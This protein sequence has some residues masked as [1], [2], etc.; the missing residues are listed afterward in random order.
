MAKQNYFDGLGE[1]EI[2]WLKSKWGFFSASQ[3][4]NLT[5]K[6]RRPMTPEELKARP[7]GSKLT[8][9][10][11]VFGDAALSYIHKV[12]TERLTEFDVNEENF[13]SRSMRRGK[14][15]E[16]I[17][18][19]N[20]NKRLGFE[21]KNVLEYYGGD[22]PIFTM[23]DEYSGVSPDVLAI[24]DRKKKELIGNVSFGVEL[25]NPDPKQHVYYLAHVRTP[26]ELQAEIPFHYGQV[27]KAMMT[28]KTDLWLWAS[29][30]ERMKNFADRL[31][32]VEV[33]A[34]KS[35]QLNLLMR[36]KMAEKELDDYIE[37]I[38]RRRTE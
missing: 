23:F 14:L 17:S 38:T 31:L 2:N 9:V 7:Q 21:G 36:L 25:K 16:P 11:T 26:K 3:I 13:E 29:F 8:T 12:A 10:E 37:R 28:Y 4:D 27:Q 24:R 22:N 1:K 20:L 15:N 32:I 5:K 6:G 34:D 19:F 35:Y 18:F 30:N 33:P